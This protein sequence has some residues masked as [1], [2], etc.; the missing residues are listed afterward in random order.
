MTFICYSVS[1]SYSLHPYNRRVPLTT[2]TPPHLPTPRITR[3]VA[4]SPSPSH[5][6]DFLQVLNLLRVEEINPEYMLE[7]SFFQFQNYAAIPGLCDREW[8]GEA[9]RQTAL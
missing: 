6:R 5:L 9:G 7:R 1:P 3:P 2:P 8:G 4:V